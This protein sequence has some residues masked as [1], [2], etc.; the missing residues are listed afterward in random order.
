MKVIYF[1]TKSCQT[2]QLRICGDDNKHQPKIRIV[3]TG[4]WLGSKKTFL[5][6]WISYEL[7][8]GLYIYMYIY[9]SMYIFIY[10]YIH[11]HTL[12]LYLYIYIYIY[13]WI[14][15]D[16]ILI[17]NPTYPKI[18]CCRAARRLVGS[19]L[20]AFASGRFFFLHEAGSGEPGIHPGY[21]WGS[22]LYLHLGNSHSELERSTIFNR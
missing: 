8:K 3:D 16:I 20:R 13:I 11:A 15:I 9:I 1:K 17:D 18:H 12:S 2:C 14:Y 21:E 7:H 5:K 22:Y 19:G 10:I 6:T 4:Q